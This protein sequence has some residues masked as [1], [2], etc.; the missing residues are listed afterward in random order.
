MVPRVPKLNL[1]EAIGKNSESQDWRQQDWQPIQQ[2]SSSSA[3]NLPTGE[4]TSSAQMPDHPQAATGSHT[5]NTY[6]TNTR[7]AAGV[8]SVAVTPATSFPRPND[9]HNEVNEIL[10]SG[11]P[12]APGGQHDK[13]HQ[14]RADGGYDG[15]NASREKTIGERKEG[16][17]IDPAHEERRKLQGSEHSTLG[18]DSSSGRR[19]S[20]EL[21]LDQAQH[22]P[23]SSS[24]SE[25]PS[26]PGKGGTSEDIKLRHMTSHVVSKGRLS[27]TAYA[28]MLRQRLSTHDIPE[29][30]SIIAALVEAAH[31]QE[32]ALQQ[33]EAFQR[34]KKFYEHQMETFAAD[35]E[36]LEAENAVLKHK[37]TMTTSDDTL[38]EISDRL[39]KA[40]ADRDDALET[41]KA[42]EEELEKSNW[43][44]RDMS[45]KLAEQHEF[46]IQYLNVIMYYEKHLLSCA[47]GMV[48]DLEDKVALQ[49]LQPADQSPTDAGYSP[50]T[51]LQ[52]GND[53]ETKEELKNGRNHDQG[54]MEV[55]GFHGSSSMVS[56]GGKKKWTN[57]LTPRLLNPHLPKYFRKHHKAI[58]R[59]VTNL[60][61]SA[62][63]R[64]T[65][66]QAG[67]STRRI[68]ETRHQDPGGGAP[69]PASDDPA[70]DDP[71]SDDPASDDPASHDPA[72]HDP[73]QS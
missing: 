46:C 4:T 27:P 24:S 5:N 62:S 19:L 51:S 34:N 65:T 64:S 8:P 68:M 44:V 50:L 26:P 39:M 32:A 43:A 57:L 48:I 55:S 66:T 53:P 11:S 30:D 52:S 40:Y 37:L 7:T 25:V 33:Q 13:D 38:R 10:T 69:D 70:S 47:P 6:T 59:A 60:D 71:A 1:G 17:Y 9:D 18:G 58:D 61:G 35:K 49:N 16:N 12:I 45:S 72:S 21:L 15:L 29:L 3:T 31:T 20:S 22:A 28:A 14:T 2:D 67:S 54:F 23:A 56:H 73:R 36:R 42:L 63:A 41:R